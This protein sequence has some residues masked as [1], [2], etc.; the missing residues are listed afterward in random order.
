MF[1]FA[2]LLFIVLPFLGCEMDKAATVQWQSPDASV[3]AQTGSPVSFRDGSV[4]LGSKVTRLGD[5]EV[6]ASI[7]WT[8]GA[9][10]SDSH[11]RF[12]LFPTDG[13][14]A[15]DLEAPP[16]GELQ[17]GVLKY[18]LSISKAELDTRDRFWVSMRLIG[19]D[20]KTVKVP[21]FPGQWVPLGVINPADVELV[22]RKQ[23][24]QARLRLAVGGDANLGRR[25]N[26]IS[27][28][29]G[30]S[31]A[32][33]RLTALAD[34]DLA[35]VNLESVLSEEGHIGFPK[36]EKVPHYYRGRQEQ[37]NV[38]TSAGID[39]VGSANNH[40]GDYGP[41]AL[42]DQE[43]IL[44]LAGLVGV[45]TGEGLS[46]AC[47][48]KYLERS[49]VTVAFLSV[50]TTWPLYSAAQMTPGTCFVDVKD[51]DAAMAVL[52][53]QLDA[54][55]EGAD[56]VFV[57]V[58]WGKNMK[59]RP[60]RATRRLAS[61]IIQGGADAI[62]GSSAHYLQGVEIIDG[63]PVLYDTGNILFDNHAQGEMARSGLFLLDFD[64][65]G[66]HSIQVLPLQMG[67]GRTEPALA[68]HA[69]RAMR[70]FADLSNELG[71]FV[72][73]SDGTARIVL[74]PPESRDG[75]TARAVPVSL[76]SRAV[77]PKDQAP[78]GCIVE[79][80]P[81]DAQI[82]PISWGPLTLLGFRLDTTAVDER[83]TV[84]AESWWTLD[85]AVQDNFW[86]Y[87]RA[88][89]RPHKPQDMWWADHEH[90]DWAW[91]TSRWRPGQ[92]IR[93]VYGLRP[94][95]KAEPGQFDVSVGVIRNQGRLGKPVSVTQLQ[96]R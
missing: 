38:L 16:I 29:H 6:E 37:T 32:L 55:R 81:E 74:A 3:D 28:M 64:A 26:G 67:Y 10:S 8:P 2:I 82:D 73:L 7:W 91:P 19:A 15:I 4:M 58:H 42:R 17:D 22:Q 83:R 86:I 84:W 43:R 49:G 80:V 39:V 9:R 62:L 50:D 21:P 95:R 11:F 85:E 60:K 96:Y 46:E 57:A 14:K 1:R 92:I 33:G 88:K 31:D 24:D 20:G 54:A 78:D 61:A 13:G 23:T 27:S 56:V 75:P 93:D 76:V 5:E 68:N 89:T 40:A 45:G 44:A 65:D 52:G 63:R 77:E 47:A 79:S 94:P 87:L 36:G 35:F 12:R 18:T 51:V 69:S 71:T 25:Q 41:V 70:R 66:V 72:E 30:A 90:C 59:S 53:P 34:A 48:P